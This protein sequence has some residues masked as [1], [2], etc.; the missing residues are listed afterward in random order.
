M[1]ENEQF[2]QIMQKEYCKLVKTKN[3]RFLAAGPYV[4]RMI[5]T[6]MNTESEILNFGVKE[7]SRG[8]KNIARSIS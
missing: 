2:Y 3:M 8:Y 4:Q 6:Y 1:H 7:E 5:S